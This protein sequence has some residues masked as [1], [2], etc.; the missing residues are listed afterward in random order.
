MRFA[1]LPASIGLVLACLP[2]CFAADAPDS[3]AAEF[4][5]KNVRP[6]LADHCLSCHGA[7]KPRG[8]LRLDSKA[9]FLK[10]AD[11][12]PIVVP[13]D[14]DKS[15]LIHAVRRD[16]DYKMPPPPRAQLPPESIEAL[17][18]WVKMG[19]PGRTA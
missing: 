19:A 6:V 1:A 5:E 2:T 8:G 3:H 16:G 4:F 18:T 12:G 13:G 10:G 9:A 11:D 17:T 15:N 14:P 7:E